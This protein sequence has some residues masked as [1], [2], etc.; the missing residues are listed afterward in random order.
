MKDD[1]HLHKDT[2]SDDDVSNIANSFS[3]FN[4]NLFLPKNSHKK[5]FSNQHYKKTS[6]NFASSHQSSP[7]QFINPLNDNNNHIINQ[8]SLHNHN[9]SATQSPL[10]CA[11]IYNNHHLNEWV[12]LNVGGQIFTTTKMTL[13]A[14]VS[15]FKVFYKSLLL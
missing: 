9:P 12:S 6:Q 1:I 5:V 3:N 8:S 4:S 14:Q 10:S 2:P 13:I 11:T 7:S 15:V